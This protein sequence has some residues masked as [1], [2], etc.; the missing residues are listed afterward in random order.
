M[1][2]RGYVAICVRVLLTTAH[3]PHPLGYSSV[4][5]YSSGRH[6]IEPHSELYQCHNC[7]RSVPSN[8]VKYGPRNVPSTCP[9]PTNTIARLCFMS[10]TC[11]WL[12]AA[13]WGACT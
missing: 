8:E 13:S 6:S 11:S 1:Q 4:L 3:L 12:L 9:F 7:T 2:A 5:G 10:C